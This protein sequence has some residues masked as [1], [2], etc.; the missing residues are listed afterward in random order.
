MSTD[1]VL[2]QNT[3]VEREGGEMDFTDKAVFGQL[4]G[5]G[6]GVGGTVAWVV[7]CRCR[8][9]TRVGGRGWEGDGGS[10]EVEA[11]RERSSLS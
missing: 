3:E 1:N 8:E 5:A 9:M 10:K 2:M 11:V 7:E 6:V 4:T